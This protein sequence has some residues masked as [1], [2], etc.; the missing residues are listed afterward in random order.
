MAYVIAAV[1][2]LGA[3]GLFIG[4]GAQK[5][6]LYQIRATE[7]STAAGLKELAAAVAK[8][9]GAGSFNQVAEVK[10][11]IECAHPLTAELSET[12]CVHYTMSV[13]REYEETYWQTDDKGNR[14]RQTRRGTE[15][16]ASNTR[17]V[18][19]L[20]RDASG[21][22][23]VEPT[24]A[25]VVEEKVLSRFEPAGMAGTIRFGSFSFDAGRFV[26]TGDRRTIGYRLEE[27]AIPVGRNIYVLGEAVDSDGRLRIRK[28]AAKGGAFIVSLKDE[29]Q[30][31]KGARSA[32]IGMTVGGFVAAAAGVVSAVLGVL[33]VF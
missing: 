25:K 4:S 5:R 23:E 14:T 6:K 28:P 29:E 9:I 18:P 7:T 10:G 22:I 30:L 19:F 11:T 33:G 15:S 21:T 12:P 27:S 8:H 31:V 32:S 16:M 26:N 20:V 17:S 24:G 13:T 2:V 1:L 3:A